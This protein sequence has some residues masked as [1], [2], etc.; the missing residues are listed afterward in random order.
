MIHFGFFAYHLLGKPLCG[1]DVGG[2]I[3]GQRGAHR[4]IL[5][6]PVDLYVSGSRTNYENI[7]LNTLLKN[8]GND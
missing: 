7:V 8:V 5:V 4:D 6:I 1:T 2:N 3:N